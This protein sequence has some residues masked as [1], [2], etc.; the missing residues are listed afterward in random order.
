MQTNPSFLVVFYSACVLFIQCV[1]VCVCVCGDPEEPDKHV[2]KWGHVNITMDRQRA[3]P[4]L[5]DL[6][7]LLLC[8]SDFW[9]DRTPL[10]EAAYQGRLLHLRGLIAQV[11]F[12]SWCENTT[13]SCTV[14]ACI[15]QCCP[16]CRA[17]TWTRCPW[18]ESLLSMK[19]V[20]GVIT[21]VQSSC[22]IMVQM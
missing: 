7:D 20:S 5:C 14:H 15:W 19:L 6:P 4:Y 16:L 17:S 18:T 10:H 21:L 8:V 12:L 9:S 11:D 3:G 22:W 13:H 2:F 1:C